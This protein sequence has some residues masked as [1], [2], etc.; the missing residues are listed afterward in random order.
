[1]KMMCKALLLF[2]LAT[3][4]HGIHLLDMCNGSIICT[5]EPLD[6][7][8]CLLKNVFV[9]TSKIDRNAVKLPNSSPAQFKEGALQVLCTAL[10]PQQKVLLTNSFGMMSASSG[11]YGHVDVSLVNSSAR[12]GCVAESEMDGSNL[13]YVLVNRDMTG[14][15]FHSL[16]NLAYPLWRASTVLKVD[17]KQ[18]TSV[19]F[20]AD[21]MPLSAVDDSLLKAAFGSGDRIRTTLDPL[22]CGASVLVGASRHWRSWLHSGNVDTSHLSGF[23]DWIRQ[24]YQVQETVDMSNRLVV[25]VNRTDTRAI[26]NMNNLR[27]AL[28]DIG[29]NV[30]SVQFE[31]LSFREQLQLVSK[32]R[33]LIGVHGAALSFIPF[34]H[35]KKSLSIELL[36]F[37][38]VEPQF[39]TYLARLANVN[40]IALPANLEMQTPAII[41]ARA[42]MESPVMADVGEI[43][44]AV[45]TF[46]RRDMM[47]Q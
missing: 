33:V 6:T 44:K 7:R 35:P 19:A 10:E 40:H 18:R 17:L 20:V 27:A 9:D 39:F 4:C 38:I 21:S 26:A 13:V 45:V 16:Y 15:V 29:V 14:N 22:H 46:F 3:F 1:M 5:D 28:E 41:E 34:L 32:A 23:L 11:I 31:H 12:G 24:I 36:P 42:P 30:Q 25:L 47:M 2:T 43:V 8:V 37:G